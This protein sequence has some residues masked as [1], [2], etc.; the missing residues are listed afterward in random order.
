MIT[1]LDMYRCPKCDKRYTFDTSKPFSK[2][3]PRCNVVM[4]FRLNFNSDTELAAI[5]KAKQAQQEAIAR[6]RGAECPYCKSRD[7][8][9]I[10]TTGRI[11]S[12][13][14]FGL[15]SNKVGKQWHCNYCNS[16]F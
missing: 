11:L 4:E 13:G 15:G 2:M 3:C 9:K 8:R 16:D 12:T 6:G 7:T 10:S 1:N 5:N 14:L